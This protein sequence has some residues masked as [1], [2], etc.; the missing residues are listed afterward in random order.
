MRT[1]RPAASILLVSLLALTLAACSTSPVSV[2]GSRDR[3]R[4]VPVGS[5][6]V[7]RLPASLPTPEWRLNSWDSVKLRITRRLALEPAESGS[8]QEWVA[9]FVTRAPGQVD[10]EYVRTA[11]A[12]GAD[13]FVGQNKRFQFRIRGSA[14]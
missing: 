6:V 9:R 13:G 2:T 1:L 4:S 7:I 8:G 11:I 5:E 14:G 3:T 10:I 12:R